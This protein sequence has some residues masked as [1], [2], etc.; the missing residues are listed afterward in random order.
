MD[1]C[2]FLSKIEKPSQK[3]ARRILKKGYGSKE[4]GYGLP[5]GDYMTS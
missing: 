3:E 2:E 1:R 4:G 5:S